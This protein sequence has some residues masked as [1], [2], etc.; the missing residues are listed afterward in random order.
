MSFS[1]RKPFKGGTAKYERKCPTESPV[2]RTKSLAAN[3]PPYKC[4]SA[5]RLK[6]MSFRGSKKFEKTF[7][8]IS[9][10]YKTELCRNWERG[11]CSFGDACSFAHGLEQLKAK[12]H[13]S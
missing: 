3:S 2:K 6:D 13:V 4:C 7:L 9:E 5:R 1:D 11:V 10:R 12:T 8:T